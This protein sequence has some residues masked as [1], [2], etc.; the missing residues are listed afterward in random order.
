M[1]PFMVTRPQQINP[2][3]ML[4]QL[5]QNPSAVLQR[6]G[7]NVP[8]GMTNPQ[9]IINHLLQSGQMT[10]SRLQALQNAARQMNGQL[11]KNGGQ[12]PHSG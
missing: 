3:Q 4:Q 1:N 12:L 2:M 10:N 7:Y 11:P 6:A 9:Q 5:R 8:D